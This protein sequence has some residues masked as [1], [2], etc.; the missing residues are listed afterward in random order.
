M[1]YHT[2]LTFNQKNSTF[3]F[4]SCFS[5][6]LLCATS[7]TIVSL[8]NH[9]QIQHWSVHDLNF[10]EDLK[11]NTFRQRSKHSKA[12]HHQLHPEKSIPPKQF[13][14]SS[15]YTFVKSLGMNPGTLSELQRCFAKV[16][17][18]N[19]YK[20][21]V[22]VRRYEK[23]SSRLGPLVVGISLNFPAI[24]PLKICHFKKR[25]TSKDPWCFKN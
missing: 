2:F 10:A 14:P 15:I 8:Q 16:T 23:S 9:I 1:K 17:E 25:S 13:R 5:I 6:F 20:L 19:N 21:L 22:P 18:W 7:N 3:G 4:I 12:F 11:F 24:I